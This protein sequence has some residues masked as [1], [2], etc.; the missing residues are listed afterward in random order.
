MRCQVARLPMTLQAL[1]LAERKVAGK[2]ARRQRESNHAELD[3]DIAAEQRRLAVLQ[4]LVDKEL[5]A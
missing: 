3:Q 4:R 2:V 5:A 1:A